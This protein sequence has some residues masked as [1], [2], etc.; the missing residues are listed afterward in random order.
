MDRIIQIIT[1]IPAFE[2]ISLLCVWLDGSAAPYLVPGLDVGEAFPMAAFFLLMSAYVVPDE[3]NREEFSTQLELIDRKGNTQGQG[4]LGWY[5]VQ[6]C[7]HI[8][9]IRKC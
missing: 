5:R 8:K 2:I 6:A 9:S 4:S 1:I 7:E 3:G